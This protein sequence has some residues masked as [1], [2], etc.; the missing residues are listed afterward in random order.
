MSLTCNATQ[1]GGERRSSRPKGGGKP[2]LRMRL[3]ELA[4]SRPRFGYRRLHMLQR[5]EGWKVN[6]KL[7]HRL[8]CEKGLQVRTRR[9]RKVAMQ[10][11]LSLGRASG[12]NE[13]CS[14]DFVTDQLADG[15]YFRIFTVVDQFSRECGALHADFAIR[16]KDVGEVLDDA[17]RRRSALAGL[18]RRSVTCGRR[19]G[20]TRFCKNV[21]VKRDL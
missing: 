8:Y 15:R 20:A 10:P 1:R 6:H 19:R 17:I 5:R 11:R 4:S 12:V 7:I 2:T 13:R 9:G 18:P 21:G 3:R 14:M 16:S